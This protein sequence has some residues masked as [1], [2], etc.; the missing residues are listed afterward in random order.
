MLP[1]TEKLAE[2]LKEDYKVPVMPISIEA[3]GERDM[4]NILK[5]ALYEFTI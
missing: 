3:M 5:E 2:K 4:Y 1:E